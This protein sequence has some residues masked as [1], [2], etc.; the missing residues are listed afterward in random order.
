MHKLVQVSKFSD[1]TRPKGSKHWY[2]QKEKSPQPRLGK[3][4]LHQKSLQASS[5][6]GER[7]PSRLQTQKTMIKVMDPSVRP[8]IAFGTRVP[9]QQSE[10]D[11]EPPTHRHPSWG[12]SQQKSKPELKEPT[13]EAKPKI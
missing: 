5:N 8:E 3:S 12:G 9:V 11:D 10:S 13:S 4:L 6:S 7:L 2:E 1:G